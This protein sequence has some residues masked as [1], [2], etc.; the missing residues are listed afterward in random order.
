MQAP[1]LTSTPHHLFYRFKEH[2]TYS[3]KA[4]LSWMNILELDF[5][6]C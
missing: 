3:L 4:F 1:N 6:L 5:A 2:Q